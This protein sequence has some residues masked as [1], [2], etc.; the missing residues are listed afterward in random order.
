MS[1]PKLLIA[2]SNLIKPW[3]I[4]LWQE[5]FDVEPY[6]HDQTY[7]ANSIVVTDNRFGETKN[8]QQIQ[9]HNYR[10]ILPY[11]MDS[12]VDDTCEIV[13]GELILRAREWVWIQESTQWRFLNYYVSRA[14]TMPSK[15]F[16]LLMNLKRKSRDLLFQT[17]DP[18]LPSSIYSYVEHGIILPEDIFIPTPFNKG[19]ANDRL[20]V[21]DWYAQTCFSLVAETFIKPRLFVSE[22]IFKP[23]AYH[24]PFIVYGTPGSLA[25]L[26]SLGFETFG[27]C[28]D[29]SYDV[30]TTVM[31]K[32]E[33]ILA[34]LENLH[35]EFTHK[36]TVFQDSRTQEILA[37]NH[38][39]FFDQPRVHNLFQQQIVRPI[40]DFLESQ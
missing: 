35:K 10:I 8:Y 23:L 31:A 3:F 13:N 19:N 30:E 38:A 36:G 29:E 40:M 15:F 11:L 12:D 16:L 5:F 18:Y 9:Q 37:H 28:I 39:L 7:E 1:K 22:K 32:L 21:P 20:Y 4:P 26:H 17:V 2:D 34:V 14:P 24:H 25:Y 33:K 27:H 6:S